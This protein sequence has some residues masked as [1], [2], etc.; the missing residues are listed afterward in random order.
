MLF[1]AAFSCVSSWAS[2]GFIEEYKAMS[3]TVA[4][5]KDWYYDSMG[6][7][8]LL[9]TQDAAKEA[10]LIETVDGRFLVAS[11]ADSFCHHAAVRFQFKTRAIPVSAGC[12]AIDGGVWFSIEATEQEFQDITNEFRLGSSVKVSFMDHKNAN[13]IRGEHLFS[14]MGYSA[15]GEDHTATAYGVD[16]EKIHAETRLKPLA[17][18]KVLQLSGYID[19]QSFDDKKRL[20]AASPIRDPEIKKARYKP[21]PK[22]EPD[23]AQKYGD[24][25]ARQMENKYHPACAAYA[26]H[27]RTMA[28]SGHPANVRVMQIDRMVDR[29]PSIC[30]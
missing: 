25:L 14:L 19:K 3:G 13:A 27:I 4:K 15:A 6:E 8:H 20:L 18:E 28:S 5:H 12:E 21:A 11:K 17:K 24:G 10:L 16:I 30:F 9:T 2:D 29:A 1:A 7:H 26:S 23:F 22:S